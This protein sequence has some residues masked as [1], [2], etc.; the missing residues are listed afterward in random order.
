[1]IDRIDIEGVSNV[2]VMKNVRLELLVAKR[3]INKI[4]IEKKG[5]F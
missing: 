2:P 4:S 5:P 1:M 3:S